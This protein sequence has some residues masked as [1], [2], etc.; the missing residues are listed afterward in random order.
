MHWLTHAPDPHSRLQAEVFENLFLPTAERVEENC[1]LLY[2][3]SIERYEAEL[4][5][6]LFIFCMIFIFFLN[7]MVLKFCK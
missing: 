7:V 1:D 6:W 4:K 3:N 5:N 2:Q